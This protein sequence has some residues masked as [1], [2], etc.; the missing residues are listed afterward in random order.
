M[1]RISSSAFVLASLSVGGIAH[2]EE[3]R[4]LVAIIGQANAPVVAALRTELSL[5]GFGDA[6]YAMP[7]S[8]C[9]G[10]SARGIVAAAAA[11]LCVD[12][13]RVIALTM[14]GGE[15]V[16]TDTFANDADPAVVALRAAETLRVRLEGRAR[17]GVPDVTIPPTPPTTSTT[18]SATTTSTTTN[19]ITQR[20]EGADSFA[21]AR[22]SF[23]TSASVTVLIASTSG[24][25]VTAAC[26]GNCSSSL[27]IGVLALAHASTRLPFGI[28]VG[29]AAGWTGLQ[30]TFT[31]RSV[32]ASPVGYEDNRGVGTDTLSVKGPLAGVS[33]ALERGARVRLLG[34]MSFGAA[35]L[36]WNDARV[37]RLTLSGAGASRPSYSVPSINEQGSIV[38]PFFSGDLRVSYALTKSLSVD[39]GVTAL[40][41]VG[42]RSVQST[43]EPFYAGACPRSDG[44]VCQGVAT[45]HAEDKFGAGLLS[46]GPSV[47]FTATF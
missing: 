12:G 41:I 39:G 33:L 22:W 24:G 1:K 3:P 43:P 9:F 36:Q 7:S 23:A 5:K 15:L 44:A 18:T 17:P 34:R 46:G 37:S 10:T 32:S 21:R 35:F 31:D 29:F 11:A 4:H 45:Y 14:H 16:V 38:A 42:L 26:D 19:E 13:E 2:A 47:G 40:A 20:D 8:G 27:G 28:D 6:S 30:K 25:S